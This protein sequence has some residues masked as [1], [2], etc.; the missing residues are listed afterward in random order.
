MSTLRTVKTVI[1]AQKVNMGGHL[2]DQPLPAQGMDYVDPFLLIHHWES[3]LPGGQHQRD[4]GVGPHPHRG[5]SPVTFVYK[6]NVEHRDSLGNNAIVSEGGTQWMFAG[7]GITHSERQ[8]RDLAENGGEVEF[9]Q[10]WVNAP[11]DKKMEQAFYKPISKEDTPLVEGPKS[12]I[13]VV[14][15]EFNGTKG[16]APTYSPQTLLRGEL[17][18]GGEVTIPLPKNYNALLYLLDGG[19]VAS[20]KELRRKDMAV[21]Y[22]DGEEIR[23][24]A[25]ENTRFMLLSGEPLNEAVMSY[26]PFVMTNETEILEA[27]RDSQM[28]KM[29]VLIEEFN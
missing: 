21:F 20:G 1:P 27:L 28:G 24:T 9:I 15:G 4:V 23:I 16:A 13:W 19:L 18:A 7:R 2:L 12:K 5:F 14:S 26:G 8:G 10:F 29:G 25:S 6:G 17:E 11:S 22:N 3:T